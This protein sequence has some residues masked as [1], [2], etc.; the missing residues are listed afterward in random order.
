RPRAR[1]AP[2]PARAPPPPAAPTPRRAT[3]P[4]CAPSSS[5]RRA[6]PPAARALRHRRR[7]PPPRRGAPLRSQSAAIDRSSCLASPSRKG[8][9]RRRPPGRQVLGQRLADVVHAL[10]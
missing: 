10:A 6:P 5:R 2:P 4:P 8:L 7:A 1:P 3:P 9:A